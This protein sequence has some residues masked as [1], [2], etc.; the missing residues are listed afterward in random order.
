MDEEKHVQI[1]F[2]IIKPKLIDANDIAETYEL[3]FD[4][5]AE[6][7]NEELD[8]LAKERRKNIIAILEAN[9]ERD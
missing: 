9:N 2:D 5:I 8:R 4:E 7:F 3:D 6:A 1:M